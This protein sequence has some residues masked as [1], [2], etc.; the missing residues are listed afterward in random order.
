MRYR[1]HC[2]PV[3]RQF[4]CFVDP[5]SLNLQPEEMIYGYLSGW[6]M[7]DNLE[8]LSTVDQKDAA[9]PNMKYIQQTSSKNDLCYHIMCLKNMEETSTSRFAWGAI[10]EAIAAKSNLTD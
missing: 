6:V 4:V 8:M 1:N 10:V 2:D 3:K 7:K 5:S 9:D